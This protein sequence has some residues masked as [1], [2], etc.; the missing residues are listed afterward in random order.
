MENSYAVLAAYLFFK[1][2]LRLKLWL[3]DNIAVQNFNT[4]RENGFGI[5]GVKPT[6]SWERKNVFSFVS[7]A[8][9]KLQSA[10]LPLSMADNHKGVNARNNS[11]GFASW[12]VMAM[13]LIRTE[14]SHFPDT[15]KADAHKTGA[16]ASKDVNRAICALRCA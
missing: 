5:P 6:T 2:T 11:L 9:L 4:L 15:G 16:F 10:T 7:S 13:Q 8:D 14:P 12:A 1:D 3:E